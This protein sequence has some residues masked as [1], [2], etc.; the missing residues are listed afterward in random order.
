MK[1]LQWPSKVSSWSYVI[2]ICVNKLSL[3]FIF[4]IKTKAYIFTLACIAQTHVKILFSDSHGMKPIARNKIR[5]YTKVYVVFWV[6]P[7]GCQRC[8]SCKLSPKNVARK[9]CVFIDPFTCTRFARN[10]FY[11]VGC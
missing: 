5:E 4:S 9:V 3:F 2:R 1:W 10:Y 8:F 11:V 6:G 7:F